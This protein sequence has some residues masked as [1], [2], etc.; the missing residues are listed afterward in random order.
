M[1]ILQ[2]LRNESDFLPRVLFVK[3]AATGA[4]F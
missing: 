1:N 4:V 3:D 2:P